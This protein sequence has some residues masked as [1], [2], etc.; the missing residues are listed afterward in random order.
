MLPFLLAMR[1]LFGCGTEF[2]PFIAFA[3]AKSESSYNAAWVSRD[4]GGHREIG[5]WRR[6]FPD[7]WSAP[8]FCGYWQT[9]A[10]SERE[11]LLHRDLF[12]GYLVRMVEMRVWL[13]RCDG[14]LRCALGGYGCGNRGTAH[15]ER[16]GKRSARGLSYPDRIIL[17]AERLQ[18]RSAWQSRSCST[19][20]GLASAAN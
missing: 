18:R 6:S 19:S 1:V 14:N 16:C 2:D 20:T 3:Q 4:V 13:A 10:R 8:Y 17:R 12:V 7:H 9:R 11:C 5:V 15:P